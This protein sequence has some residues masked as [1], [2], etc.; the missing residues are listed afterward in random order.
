M[1]RVPCAG[2]VAA[3][4]THVVAARVRSWSDDKVEWAAADPAFGA[5]DHIH[6]TRRGYERL[7]E[8]LLGAMMRGY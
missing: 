2:T 7:G 1:T 5:P 8:A 3:R 6:Y 4:L